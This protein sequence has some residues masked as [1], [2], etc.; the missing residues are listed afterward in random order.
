M[1]TLRHT[2]RLELMFQR[3]VVPSHQREVTV[4][5]VH[6][7]PRLHTTLP[8]IS[9]ATRDF[10]R[11]GRTIASSPT[12]LRRRLAEGKHVRAGLRVKVRRRSRRAA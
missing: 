11:T 10:G 4:V 3:S 5:K 9:P 1:L 12:R 7:S 2:E 6:G 8:P